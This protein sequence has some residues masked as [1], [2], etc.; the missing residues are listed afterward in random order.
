MKRTNFLYLPLSLLLLAGCS[1]QPDMT[2]LAEIEASKSRLSH[3]QKANDK[4]ITDAYMAMYAQWKG[5]PYLYGGTSFQGVDC[6]AFVQTIVRD[7]TQQLLPR[8]THKQ[9]THGIEVSY[10]EVRSGDLVFFKTSRTTNHVGVYL[11]NMQFLHASTSKGVIISRL[12]NPYWASVFWQF[13][14]V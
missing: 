2:R 1:S 14:R 5:V 11:G 13:R 12:D 7:A 6:S 8:T 9:S 10:S 4:Q 3:T